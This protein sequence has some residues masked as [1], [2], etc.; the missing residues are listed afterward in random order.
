MY[1][2]KSIFILGKFITC[3]FIF[4]ASRTAP[5]LD[6]VDNHEK[7]RPRGNPQDASEST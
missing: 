1:V 7:W 5:P 3:L 4:I 6:W 2:I